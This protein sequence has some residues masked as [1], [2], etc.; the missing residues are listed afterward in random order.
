MN[1]KTIVQLRTELEARRDQHT[2]LVERLNEQ[3]EGKVKEAKED[4]Q[5]LLV[6]ILVSHPRW[7]SKGRTVESGDSVG[8]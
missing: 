2:K 1:Q 8:V 7:P 6:S 5:R 4:Y 3:W